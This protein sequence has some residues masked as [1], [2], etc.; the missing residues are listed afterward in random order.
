M[1][2]TTIRAYR[3][4]F[5]ELP[6]PGEGWLRLSLSA[7]AILCEL[8]PVEG[9]IPTRS[10]MKSY[11]CWWDDPGVIQSSPFLRAVRKVNKPLVVLIDEHGKLLETN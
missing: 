6:A 9:P 1:F 8:H 10:A 2:G 3:Q 4:G 11:V 5:R 7:D